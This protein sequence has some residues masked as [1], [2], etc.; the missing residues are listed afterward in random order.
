MFPP[1]VVLLLLSAASQAGTGNAGMELSFERVAVLAGEEAA[2]P[3]YLVSSGNPREPFH[4]T[5]EFSSGEL[6]FQKVERAYLAEKAGWQL[7]AA[8]RDH[9]ERKGRRILQIHVDPGEAPFF[10]SGGV[11]HAHFVVAKTQG[12]GDILLDAALA[13]PTSSKPVPTAQPAK[14][15]VIKTAVF[16]CFLYMH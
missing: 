3:I 13:A 14:I 11:A 4:I 7:K 10:P 9:P 1:F 5:L 6:T 16:G 2:L 12:E 8:V 15:S